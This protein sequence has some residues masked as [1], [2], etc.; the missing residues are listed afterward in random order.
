MTRPAAERTA[1][2]VG[3]PGFLR[4]EFDLFL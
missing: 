3:G 4:P 1:L 2:P